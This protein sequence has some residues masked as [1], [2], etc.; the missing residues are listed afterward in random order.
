MFP[1]TSNGVGLGINQVRREGSERAAEM[2]VVEG[3]GKVNKGIRKGAGNEA[4][5]W[6]V[7]GKYKGSDEKHKKGKTQ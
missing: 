3:M 4:E 7:Q 2:A 1:T 5:S 6:G